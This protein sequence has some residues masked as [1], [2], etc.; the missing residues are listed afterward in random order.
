MIIVKSGWWILYYFNL[1]F[2]LFCISF[3]NAYYIVT[4]KAWESF[5]FLHLFP[6]L[7]W[8]YTHT[9]VCLFFK[10]T[11]LTIFKCAV[12]SSPFT[13][14]VNI[15]TVCFQNVFIFSNCNSAL[16]KH[17]LCTPSTPGLDN[18][19]STLC[20]WISLLWVPPV[21]GIAQSW[22]LC[23]WLTLFSLS[24]RPTRGD[25]FV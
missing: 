19:R 12:A 20:L 17:W 16:I 6:L 5:E 22:S 24:S 13:L 8:L 11:V 1:I 18:P 23:I 21:N 15:T 2:I 14:R 7:L 3:F 25:L 9:Y 10:F 4:N